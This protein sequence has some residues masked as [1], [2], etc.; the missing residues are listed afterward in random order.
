M[1]IVFLGIGANLG[2]R[3]GHCERAVALLRVRPDVQVTACSPWH[4]YPALTRMPDEVQPEYVNGVVQI[5]TTLSPQDLLACCTSIERQLGRVRDP[6]HRWT[7]RTIDIDLLLYDDLVLA[8]PMLTIPHP[9]LAKRLFVLEPLAM[10]VPH[11][12]HPVIRKPL[13]ELYHALLPR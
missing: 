3:R 2:D 10:L 5:A 4:T 11:L 6:Q 8:T 9:E 13:K 1:A 7:P 12:V